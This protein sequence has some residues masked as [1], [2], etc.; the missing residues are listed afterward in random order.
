[1]IF[2]V[3]LLRIKRLYFCLLC[4]E[5]HIPV[6]FYAAFNKDFALIQ[7]RLMRYFPVLQFGHEAAEF[8][9]GERRPGSVARSD[10]TRR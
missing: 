5:R 10:S 9:G 4:H 2:N 1:M 7:I 6:S 3:S 8:S